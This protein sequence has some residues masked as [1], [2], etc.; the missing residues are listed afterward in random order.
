MLVKATGKQ[1]PKANSHKHR[2]ATGKG[3]KTHQEW[4]RNKWFRFRFRVVFFAL[5]M[6]KCWSSIKFKS[7]LGQEIT[8]NVLCKPV[9]KRSI[10]NNH[11][12]SFRCKRW[13]C[14]SAEYGAFRQA[15][16]NR[17]NDRKKWREKTFRKKRER[18][19]IEINE[20]ILWNWLLTARP[21]CCRCLKPNI[22]P[23]TAAKG[24]KMPK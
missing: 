5:S 14:R 2:V 18:K 7:S 15:N 19:K 4:D 11:I 23:S 21:P 16:Q 10:L 3:A 8:S 1:R 6:F 12:C 9:E 22:A 17:R 24:D 13:N 20:N